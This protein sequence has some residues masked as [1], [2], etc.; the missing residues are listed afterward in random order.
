MNE[1]PLKSPISSENLDIKKKKMYNK[2]QL[3]SFSAIATNEK[4]ANT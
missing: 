4:N 2:L 3:F 1:F